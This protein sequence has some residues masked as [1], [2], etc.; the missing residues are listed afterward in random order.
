MLAVT[1]RAGFV[2]TT[3]R[4]QRWAL[5]EPEHPPSAPVSTGHP[6]LCRPPWVCEGSGHN[7]STSASLFFRFPRGGSSYSSLCSGCSCSCDK[8][9]RELTGH[10]LLSRTAAQNSMKP[11]VKKCQSTVSDKEILPLPKEELVP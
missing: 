9:V 8:R 5:A 2:P 6:R 7:R 4:L 11:A 1:A 10:T 3:T